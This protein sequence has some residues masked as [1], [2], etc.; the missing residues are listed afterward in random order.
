L[1]QISLKDIS[2]RLKIKKKNL[3][4]STRTKIKKLNTLQTLKQNNKHKFMNM[5]LP[6]QPTICMFINNMQ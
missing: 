5:K 6:L 4:I 1:N 2:Q 3:R